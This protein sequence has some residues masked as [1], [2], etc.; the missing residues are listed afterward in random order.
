[1][2][3][4][5]RFRENELASVDLAL[6]SSEPALDGRELRG[7]QEPRGRQP[8]R[9]GDAPGD[10]VRVELEIDLERRREAFELR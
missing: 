4:L 8:A 9:V 5:V 10:V 1:V 2:D 7:C 6:D 3:V